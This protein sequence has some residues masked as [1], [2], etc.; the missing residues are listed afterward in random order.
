MEI[1]PKECECVSIDF[2][3]S[4]PKGFHGKIYPHSS[5][6]K[7]MITVDP[8][9]R[10]SD[11]RGIVHILIINNSNKDFTIC[12]GNRIAQ[13]VF[14]KGFDGIFIKVTKRDFLGLTKR[15]E[16]GFGSTDAIE[17]KKSK[18]TEEQQKSFDESVSTLTNFSKAGILQI[19][20]NS[21]KDDLEIIEEE[22]L[23]KVEDEVVLHNKVT[24][25][26]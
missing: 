1:F 25:D 3:W 15:G 2:R 8:G 9:I 24:I 18:I 12:T 17:I 7:K 19:V 26:Y 22:V 20:Q 4:I 6:V 10:D 23:M 5:L 13:V 21:K 14:P 11:Y 16:G